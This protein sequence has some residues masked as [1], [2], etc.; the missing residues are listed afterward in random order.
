MGPVVI[1]KMEQ[2]QRQKENRITALVEK[3]HQQLKSFPTPPSFASIPPTTTTEATIETNAASPVSD[4]HLPSPP[5]HGCRPPSMTDPSLTT[6]AGV[7]ETASTPAPF[8][9]LE[10]AEE[11]Y[12][13]YMLIPEH[14]FDPSAPFVLT[15]SAMM[16]FPQHMQEAASFTAIDPNL[17]LSQLVPI[18]VVAPF[19]SEVLDPHLNEYSSIP[20]AFLNINGSPQMLEPMSME[21]LL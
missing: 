2:N 9:I 8:Y 16:S 10:H 1:E 7:A 17:N 21:G 6:T 14:Y 15:P 13:Q 4:L 5:Q 3:M 19:E 18:G 12:P 20:T 11:S